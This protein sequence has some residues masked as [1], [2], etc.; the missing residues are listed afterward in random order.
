MLGSWHG[1]LYWA[2]A[3][4]RTATDFCSRMP[5]LDLAPRHYVASCTVGAL[6][7]RASWMKAAASMKPANR[8]S[9]DR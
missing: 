6:G 5:G 4:S 3:W 9:H 8:T 2:A 1:K 7:R